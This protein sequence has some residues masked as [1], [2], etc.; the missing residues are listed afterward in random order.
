[1]RS[2]QDIDAV[3]NEVQRRLDAYGQRTGISLHVTQDG[4]V[5][6]DKWLNIVVTP[7]NPGVRAYEYVDALGEVEKDLRSNG[8]GDVLLVPALAD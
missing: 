3:L 2:K 6:D 8:H 7:T 1:M 4:Y 5:Q